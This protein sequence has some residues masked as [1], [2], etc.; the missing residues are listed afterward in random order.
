MPTLI[1]EYEHVKKDGVVLQRYFGILKATGY[2]SV[3]FLQRMSTNDISVVK[4][5]GKYSITVLTNEKAKII[6]IITVINVGDYVLIITSSDNNQAVMNWLC[7]YII[8]ENI[9]ISDVTLDYSVWFYIGSHVIDK[10]NKRYNISTNL[11]ANAIY[12]DLC[13]EVLIYRDTTWDYLSAY[14]VLCKKEY[15]VSDELD[16]ARISDATFDLLRV[17][18]GIP[19][20]GHEF[21]L[22]INPL[23]AG[24]DQF[25]SYTKGCYIGQEVISRLNTYNK[26]QKKLIGLRFDNFSQKIHNAGKLYVSSTEVG[27]TTSHAW[28]HKLG[29]NIALGYLKESIDTEII[30][31]KN[32][33]IESRI[34][35]KVAT[36]PFIK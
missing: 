11:N 33:Q 20:Y 8:T 3:D 30:A 15:I 31:F 9:E 13:N 29:K 17:E 24:L 4:E 19:L 18:Y 25:I 28:S 35:V 14:C 36:L 5:R 2:D 1:E 32:N 22:N 34:A 7:K 26:V 16:L 6:D 21:T 10:L 12:Y 23:E 27:F